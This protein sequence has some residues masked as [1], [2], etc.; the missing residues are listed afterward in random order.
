VFSKFLLPTKAIAVAAV[1]STGFCATPAIGIVTA[2]GHFMVERSEVWGN[3]TLF[4]GATIQTEDASSELALRNGVKLQLG[5]NSRAQVFEN[6]LKL[7]RGAGQVAAQSP[8]AIEAAGLRISGERVRVTM[9]DRV[10]VAAFSG[11]AR[12]L[13]ASGVVLASIPAGRSMSFSMQAG[14]T[15][16]V[17]RTGCLLYKDGHFIQ[18]DENTQQVAELIGSNLARNTGNRVEVNGTVA[19]AKPSLSIAT[20]V[21]NVSTVSVKSTGGCLS[22][23]AALDAKAEAPAAAATSTPAAPSTPAPKPASGGM[24]TGAK[25]GIAAAVAGGGA[26]AALALAGKKSSTSP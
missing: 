3:S 1:C 9:N 5:A 15:G 10:E 8:Y 6:H 23:A 7:E 2:A 21:I 19:S 25:V 22:V 11:T 17:T 26:G 4:D 16:A 20:V 18:Q 12:V 13:A 14:A 24:S